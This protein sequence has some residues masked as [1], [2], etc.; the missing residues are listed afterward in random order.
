MLYYK[1]GFKQPASDVMS[2]QT[3]VLF[4]QYSE[5][6]LSTTYI[7]TCTNNIVNNIYYMQSLLDSEIQDCT[8]VLP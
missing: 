1:S 6:L 3:N 4:Q 8:T 7:C 2:S 5:L